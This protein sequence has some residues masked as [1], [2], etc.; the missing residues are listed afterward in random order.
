MNPLKSALSA[1]ALFSI[2]TLPLSYV[3]TANSQEAGPGEGLVILTREDK[4]KGKAM[5]F[6]MDINGRQMQL[7]AG[8]TL[9]VPLPVGTHSLSVWSPSLDGQDS[10]TI[11][12]K[13]GWTY[14]IEGYI[15]WGWPAGRTKFRFVSESGPEP[16]SVASQDRNI[17]DQGDSGGAP[18]AGASLGAAATSSTSP[19]SRTPD[20]AGRIGLR[21][22]VGDWD[23]EMWSLAA[24]GS[25]LEGRGIAQGVAE[26]DSARITFTEFSAPA[27]PA[28]TGGG[29][30]RI[31]YEEGKGFTLESWFKH[32]NE[33]LKFSGRYEADTGRYVF[34]MFGSSGEIATGVPRSSTRV[35][36]RSVDIAT[37][38]ADTYSAIEGQSVQV[39][40]YQFTR[41]SE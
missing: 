38:V 8:N 32:S 37:W 22:F 18:L 24:D 41:R 5:R 11:D 4:M 28:A 20:E 36:I 25:K 1:A 27:F 35:E 3:P 12:V 2:L 17:T 19:P 21:N 9:R 16:G 34:Y 29:Q 23:L 6:N 7:L 30:V 26:G 40:S 10:V 31:A 15:R 39:Q 14:H 13:E 33:M